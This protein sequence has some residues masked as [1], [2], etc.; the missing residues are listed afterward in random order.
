MGATDANHFQGSCGREASGAETD[1]EAETLSLPWC[2]CEVAV[3]L[4]VHGAWA[5][6]R[7]RRTF[8]P[9]SAVVVPEQC[10]S[11]ELEH[12][13]VGG[14]VIIFLNDGSY[15]LW[16]EG[17]WNEIGLPVGCQTIK[18]TKKPEKTVVL[19]MGGHLK[20]AFSLLERR[21]ERDPCNRE[22]RV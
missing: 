17:H 15:D 4:H 5:C 14:I 1:R 16:R 9:T 6:A 20:A 19:V 21:K 10:I 18:S 11:C 22:S 12:R 3:R 13:P 7:G 2:V 8:L